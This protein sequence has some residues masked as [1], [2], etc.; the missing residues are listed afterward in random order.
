VPIALVLGL[1]SWH[2]V[3]KHG[4]RL[5]STLTDRVP[6]TPADPATIDTTPTPV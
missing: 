4:L 3:E 2:L 1:G 5:R 6:A